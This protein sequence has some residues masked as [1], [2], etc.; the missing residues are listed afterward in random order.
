[1]KQGERQAPRGEREGR[2][3]TRARRAAEGEWPAEVSSASGGRRQRERPE[4][5]IFD[6]VEQEQRKRYAEAALLRRERAAAASE[7]VRRAGSVREAGSEG[8][9]GRAGAAAG[10]A[11]EMNALLSA[12]GRELERGPERRAS[13]AAEDERD[14]LRAVAGTLEG[15]RASAARF[16]E[17]VGRLEEAIAAGAARALDDARALEAALGAA[18]DRVLEQGRE[19]ARREESRQLQLLQGLHEVSLRLSESNTLATLGTK[20]Q[21]TAAARLHDLHEELIDLVQRSHTQA[22]TEM[23]R[24]HEEVRE[25]EEALARRNRLALVGS[26]GFLAILGVTLFFDRPAPAP[27]HAPAQAVVERAP[28]RPPSRTAPVPAGMAREQGD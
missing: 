13:G 4:R 18:T 2:L 11:G 22:L 25:R 6:R 26:V 24:L 23:H 16:E 9:L 3:W 17:Q 8:A 19:D 15:L 27:A 28:A 14:P 1:M 5:T 10:A 7:R 21:E 12:L 20:Q